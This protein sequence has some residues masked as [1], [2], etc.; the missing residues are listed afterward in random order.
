[1]RN[2]VNTIFL[3][4]SFCLLASGCAINGSKFSE[5][6]KISTISINSRIQMPQ[7]PLVGPSLQLRT[8]EENSL[9]VDSQRGESAQFKAIL[10]QQ[11][12]DFRNMLFDRMSNHIGVLNSKLVKSAN[13]KSAE[14]HLAV[15]TYGLVKGYWL[16][17]KPYITVKADLYFDGKII[18][19][20]EID[21]HGFSE[22]LSV[23][24]GEALKPSNL[25]SLFLSGIDYVSRDLESSLTAFLTQ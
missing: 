25:N 8:A 19:T 6:E 16:T 4:T 5:R 23:P 11:R 22:T 2:L 15:L 14:L 18:W 7:N 3:V 10:D 20:K 12:I 1:M 17:T 21:A 9:K 13:A 24:M